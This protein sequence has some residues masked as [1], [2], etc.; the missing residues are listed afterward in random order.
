MYPQFL[1]FT[2]TQPAQSA[3]RQIVIATFADRTQAQAAVDSLRGEGV[4]PE[5][6]SAVVRHDEVEVSPEEM[7][8]LDRESEEVGTD[9]AVGGTAG[10]VV[11]FL[12]GLAL[13]SIPGLGPFLGVGVL[14]TTLGGA[15]IGS[16][17]GQHV[18]E[19]NDLELPEERAQRYSG[20]FAEGHVIVALTT[21]NP[22]VV[23]KAREVFTA[24]GAD[25]IDVH[26]YRG[27]L[28]GIEE[29]L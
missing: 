7:A 17:A 15:V 21:E 24:H 18:A 29:G 9:V 23:M 13:F 10:G 14:A 26:P 4:P 19:A 8:T 11:G 28:T 22:N 20:A 2:M 25:E 12:T 27:N 6:I 3:A 5:T 16:A 1:E